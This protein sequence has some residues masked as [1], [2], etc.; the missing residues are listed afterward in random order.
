MSSQSAPGS[1]DREGKDP[2][3]DDP[4]EQRRRLPE[5]PPGSAAAQHHHGEERQGDKRE[6]LQEDGARDARC[7]RQVARPGHEDESQHGEEQGRRVGSPEPR[8]GHRQ[9]VGGECGAGGE[10]PVE[11]CVEQQRGA[12]ERE[13]AEQDEQ[14]VVVE[15][16][17]QEPPSRQ[18]SARCPGSTR[19]GRARPGG[20]S[21]RA[22]RPGTS[23]R[24]RSRG[25]RARTGSR[26]PG[27]RSPAISIWYVE[28]LT[29]YH[30]SVAS[31]RPTWRKVAGRIRSPMTAAQ[32]ASTAARGTVR[33]ART[34]AALSATTSPATS[35]ADRSSAMSKSRSAALTSQPNGPCGSV[36][37]ERT[38]KGQASDPSSGTVIATRIPRTPRTAPASRRVTCSPRVAGSR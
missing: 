29:W 26:R 8:S 12:E 11:R 34:T 13:R 19:S 9:R 35:A 16:L 14:A 23:A 10:P 37:P 20:F 32:I 25:S 24:A 31:R 27:S 3:G 33:R 18:P 2:D 6:L 36:P 17:G 28:S 4:R 21:P 1:A 22:G 7:G 5:H 15:R 30:G 38:L